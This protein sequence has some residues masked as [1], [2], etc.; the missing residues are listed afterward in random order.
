MKNLPGVSNLLTILLLVVLILLFGLGA[1]Y[2]GNLNAKPAPASSPTPSSALVSTPT[3]PLTAKACTM[4]AKICPDGT[5]VGRTGPNCEFAACPQ[6]AKNTK[7]INEDLFSVSY[8][9]TYK[10]NNYDGVVSLSKWGPTQKADTEMYDGVSISFKEVQLNGKTLNQLTQSL[11][12]EVE[13]MGVAEVITPLHQTKVNGYT[14]MSYKIR[15]LG[16]FTTYLIQKDTQS[17]SVLDI[18]LMVADPGK[19]G[20]QAE[21]EKILDSLILKK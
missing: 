17:Q 16:E 6:P 13:D 9:D 1:Y 15:G 14:A 21:V 7:S 2:L 19:V 8:P 3:P 10:V 4:E 12:K 20:F 5:S 11:V 18:E